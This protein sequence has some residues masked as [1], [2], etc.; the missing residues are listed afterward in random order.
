M[1]VFFAIAG[2]SAIGSSK[3]EELRSRTRFT[4]LAAVCS[5][6]IGVWI[7]IAVNGLFGA[8][9][10]AGGCIVSACSVFVRMGVT[11]RNHVRP[12]ILPGFLILLVAILG[13][14]W[15]A[16][17][18]ILALLMIFFMSQIQQRALNLVDRQLTDLLTRVLVLT[19]AETAT[20]LMQTWFSRFSR[21][22]NNVLLL[23]LAHRARE[24]AAAIPRA[25]STAVATD[26]LRFLDKL[27]SK[28]LDERLGTGNATSR[29]T[30]WVRVLTKAAVKRILRRTGIVWFTQ[31]IYALVLAAPPE[32][33]KLLDNEEHQE[34]ALSAPDPEGYVVHTMAGLGRI[35]NPA[36]LDRV[37][38]DVEHQAGLAGKQW[39]S[40]IA[41]RA[42]QTREEARG[43]HRDYRIEVVGEVMWGVYESI[44]GSRPAQ[45]DL[46]D[47]LRLQAPDLVDGLSVGHF[48]FDENDQLLLM[49]LNGL[50][51]T[52]HELT[53]ANSGGRE[54]KH[55][56]LETRDRRKW[57]FQ[58][59]EAAIAHEVLFVFQ[60][61]S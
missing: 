35:P 44:I 31:L 46:Y 9:L 12:S 17:T 25:R 33:Q 28:E 2:W 56:V 21:Q 6:L 51:T 3:S 61:P 38:E 16:A 36:E 45:F 24:R 60:R 32:R 48:S 27:A 15:P 1:L 11:W 19:H 52:F 41:T 50:P 8:F 7:G 18:A 22:K 20:Y 43:V 53:L 40:A 42:E 30:S 26:S 55:V 23:S 4:G 54:T 5:M 37:R 47:Q 58:Q 57:V 13:L 49:S 29:A 39:L 59:L 10:L 34:Q 14:F